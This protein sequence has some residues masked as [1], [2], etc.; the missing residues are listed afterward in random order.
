MKILGDGNSGNCLKV[1]WVCDKLKLSYDWVEI[2]T[3]KGETRTPEFL[4]LNGARAVSISAAM[5][6]SAAGSAR[7]R[8]LSAWRR[9]AEAGTSHDRLLHLHPSRASR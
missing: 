2:D 3:R 4:K 5:V 9:R 8:P 6:R 1:K 7:P